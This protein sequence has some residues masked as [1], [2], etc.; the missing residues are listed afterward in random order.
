MRRGHPEY[1]CFISVDKTLTNF[2]ADGGNG[3]GDAN[4]PFLNQQRT[5]LILFYICGVNIDTGSYSS[6]MHVGF[7]WCG[8]FIDMRDLSVST[9]YTRF[10][11]TC[12]SCHSST[13]FPIETVICRLV[14][15]T[16]DRER[17]A[18]WRR[19]SPKDAPVRSI[20]HRRSYECSL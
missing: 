10:H 1:G 15:F 2:D 8:L 16:Y 9:D 12:T 11:D 3:G 13:L 7:P 17:S 4:V 18:S 6:F 14:R 20:R 5:Y 19:L